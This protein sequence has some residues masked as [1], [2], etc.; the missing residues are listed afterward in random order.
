MT[1]GGMELDPLTGQMTINYGARPVIQTSGTLVCLLPSLQEFTGVSVAYPDPPK[2]LVYAWRGKDNRGFNPAPDEPD[3]HAQ[4]NAAQSFF[5]R[6]PQEYESSINLVAAP[7][8]SD[9]FVGQLR[10]SRTAAPSHDWATRPLNVLQPQNQWITWQGSGLMEAGLGFARALHLVIE[11][12]FLR[13]VLEQ[14]VGPPCG[15][16]SR[17]WGDWPA[18]NIFS[19]TGDNE[20]GSFEDDGTPGIIVW[21]SGSAPYARSTNRVIDTDGNPADF[22]T[23]QRTGSTP[24]S[25][26][27]PTNYASTYSVDVKGYFGRRS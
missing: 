4:T 23:H 19:T 24:A 11:G 1:I 7:D 25:T 16:T 22:T 13:L 8:G 17:T 6:R 21:T 15:G 14:T 9:F 27:D 26:T 3:S 20:G 5:T 12:G 2:G 18:G 10:L